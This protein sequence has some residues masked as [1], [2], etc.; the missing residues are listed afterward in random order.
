[1]YI[2]QTQL[3]IF[4]DIVIHKRISNTHFGIVFT[5]NIGVSVMLY[6]W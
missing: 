2:T 5:Y 3:P 4:I 1:M 6:N